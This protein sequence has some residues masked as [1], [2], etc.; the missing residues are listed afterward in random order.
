MDTC[1]QVAVSSAQE[2][3][4]KKTLES[5]AEQCTQIGMEGGA[6]S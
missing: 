4:F 6:N 1:L 2:I 5:K 3:K